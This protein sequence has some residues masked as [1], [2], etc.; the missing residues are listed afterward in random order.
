VLFL[1]GRLV[2]RRVHRMPPGRLALPRPGVRHVLELPDP[3]PDVETLRPGDRLA[4]EQ[5]SGEAS[6][7]PPS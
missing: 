2:V 3:G 5:A 6:A 4:L 7:R 1:D